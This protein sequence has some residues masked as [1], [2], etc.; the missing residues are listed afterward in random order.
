MQ[1]LQVKFN[2]PIRMFCDNTNAI[3]ISKN[4]VM[5]SK[6]KHISIK[7]HYVLEQVAEKNIKVEYI[8][9]KERVANILTK[10]LPQ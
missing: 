8:G 7:Y 3:N 6:M 5:H 4:P 10:A 9:T 1:D 2:E